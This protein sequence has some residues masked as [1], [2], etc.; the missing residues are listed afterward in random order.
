MNATPTMFKMRIAVVGVI[1]THDAKPWNSVVPVA[2]NC[3]CH[4]AQT[5]PRMSPTL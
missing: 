3:R 2:S 5:T 1:S 4:N